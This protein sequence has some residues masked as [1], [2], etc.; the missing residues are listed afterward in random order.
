MIV[1]TVHKIRRLTV[2]SS[3]MTMKYGMVLPRRLDLAGCLSIWPPTVQPYMAWQTDKFHQLTNSVIRYLWFVLHEPLHCPPDNQWHLLLTTTISIVLKP[4]IPPPSFSLISFSFLLACHSFLSPLTLAFSCRPFLPPSQVF[5]LH[6]Y[7]PSPL[8][9]MDEI[10]AALDFKNVSIVANYI[11]VI[12]LVISWLKPVL[13]IIHFKKFNLLKLISNKVI[14]D[15][16]N[17]VI[18]SKPNHTLQLGCRV[19]QKPIRRAPVMLDQFVQYI[20]LAKILS[21]RSELNVSIQ[22]SFV[23]KLHPL[24]SSLLAIQKV[25]RKAWDIIMTW[26]TNKN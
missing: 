4:H 24:S 26:L 22:T 18:I 21:F 6:H 12:W 10:D 17:D 2:T 19:A 14:K 23:P 1:W 9:V 16:R 20:I 25:G 15:E 5:A 3:A 8:Y 13:F 11:K 7:K